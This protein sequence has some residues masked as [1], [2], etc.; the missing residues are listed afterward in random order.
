MI[1]IVALIRPVHNNVKFW[2]SPGTYCAFNT[3]CSIYIMLVA[4]A[5]VCQFSLKW[6][7]L[8]PGPHAFRGNH[9]QPYSPH[10]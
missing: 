2:L 3:L 6:C 7:M 5:T 10:E 1:I 8:I 9:I 4:I